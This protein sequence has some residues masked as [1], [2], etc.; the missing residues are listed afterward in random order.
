MGSRHTRQ[1][2]AIRTALQDEGRPLP[3]GEVLE[4]ARRSQPSLG[5]ATVYRNIQAMLVDGCLRSIM[6]SGDPPRY[7]LAASPH[8]D[9]FRCI[10]CQKI[11]DLE[12]CFA[13]MN[14]SLPE[15]FQATG[16]VFVFHGI[17]AKCSSRDGQRPRSTKEAGLRMPDLSA[18]VIALAAAN[19]PGRITFRDRPAKGNPAE[20]KHQKAIT[21]SR[22]SIGKFAWLSASFL[23]CPLPA[24]RPHTVWES[25]VIA[26]LFF[27][28]H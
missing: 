4:L 6:I 1:K 18:D 22:E 5:I 20:K 16:H 21:G 27:L 24:W 17:C 10:R 26:C 2:S 8:H 28:Q 13:P 23:S 3:L 9:H 14:L 7:E 19:P 11:Y 25:D 15:G 12:G